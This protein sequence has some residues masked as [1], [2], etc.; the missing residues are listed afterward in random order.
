MKHLLT[1]AAVA[2]AVTGT[3]LAGDKIDHG[4]AASDHGFATASLEIYC[5]GILTVA[6][7]QEQARLDRTYR[8]NSRWKKDYAEGYDYIANHAR[9]N[10]LEI[11]SGPKKLDLCSLA[12]FVHIDVPGSRPSIGAVAPAIAS[13]LQRVLQFK[14]RVL[15]SDPNCLSASPFE[16]D[17]EGGTVQLWDVRREDLDQCPAIVDG[18]MRLV[19]QTDA[20]QEISKTR[21]IEAV[22]APLDFRR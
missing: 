21:A 5:K 22:F 10:V 6:D 2:L 20:G 7:S 4:K 13:L 1:A 9:F 11:D 3:A 8:N 14:W 18:A 19:E 15:R 17:R 16:Q 12:S